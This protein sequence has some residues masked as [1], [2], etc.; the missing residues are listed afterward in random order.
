MS[1]K[2]LKPAQY[3]P[4]ILLWIVSAALSLA[5]WFVL[6]RA[7]VAVA[8]AIAQAV[9]V[10]RQIERQWFLRWPVAA[11]DKFALVICGILAMI[12]IMAFEWIYRDGFIKGTIRKRVAI[13]MGIQVGLLVLGGGAIFITSRLV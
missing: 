1:E 7:L 12:S 4:F 13:V 5:D 8:A 11:L 2:K 10:E 9:P 3:A 6:R